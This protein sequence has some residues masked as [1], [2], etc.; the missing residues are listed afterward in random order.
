M[1]DGNM[2]HPNMFDGSL[3]E[4]FARP[5]SIHPT[6]KSD[7][8]SRYQ[9]MKSEIDR[10][11]KIVDVLFGSWH[12]EEHRHRRSGPYVFAFHINLP[13]IRSGNPDPVNPLSISKRG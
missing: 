10:L 4:M 7:I 2:F 13:Q 11:S 3:F 6:I 5:T 8:E 12:P 1:F 9:K